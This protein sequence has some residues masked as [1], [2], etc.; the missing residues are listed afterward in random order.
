VEAEFDSTLPGALAAATGIR[1]GNRLPTV[2]KF[3]I[4]GTASY[5]TELSDG[6]DW[7][8]NASVQHVGSRFTQPA[9]QEAGAGTF[10]NSLFFNPATGAFGS[11]A[12]T[13]GPYKLQ[14]YQLV[15]LSTGLE[16][17]SGLSVQVYVNNLL[18]EN[19]LLSLDRERGGRA[20]LGYNVGQPRTIGI[21][22]R[23]KF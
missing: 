17:D 7:S 11:G 15:N 19:P 16:W 1:D 20:R 2:P 10:T 22:A 21:T 14:D 12:Y 6:L 23:Q 18:D 3:Q 5:T 4:A 8:I 13:F 9:D